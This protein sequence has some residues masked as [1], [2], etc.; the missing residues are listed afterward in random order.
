M[1]VARAISSPTRSS[2]RRSTP[3]MGDGVQSSRAAWTAARA[4][5]LAL[6]FIAGLGSLFPRSPRFGHSPC[7]N[8]RFGLIRALHP[9][10]V[11]DRQ[12]PRPITTLYL[13][14]LHSHYGWM[15][16]LR[17]SRALPLPRDLKQCR[18]CEIPA[19]KLHRQ[20]QTAGRKATHHRERRMAGDIERRASLPR[21]GALDRFGVIDTAGR[22]HGAGA[23]QDV[24][25][26]QCALHGSDHL[27]AS[28]PRLHIVARAEERPGHQPA[29]GEPTIVSSPLPQP[30]AVYCPSL[31]LQDHAVDSGELAKCRQP[32]VA[33]LGAERLQRAG[34]V[35]ERGRHLGIG[36]HV[37]LVEMP[38]KADAKTAHAELQPARVMA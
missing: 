12:D 29:P 11:A 19:N 8:H 25:F 37:L 9:P 24:N 28:A 30:R 31:A 4:P 34:D 15:L 18:L 32:D 10:L 5:K 1:D 33:N 2:I 17:T 13:R 26:A 38:N 21:I 6:M 3:G 35:L 16:I 22:V 23:E 20:R 14:P 7:A 27:Q 36:R